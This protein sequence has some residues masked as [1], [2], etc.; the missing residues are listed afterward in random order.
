[1]LTHCCHSADLFGGDANSNYG[2]L[3]S[4][5]APERIE[6]PINSTTRETGQQPTILSK[7]NQ[8]ESAVEPVD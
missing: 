6:S 4:S 2:W 1:V 8:M 7:G 3:I 5:T